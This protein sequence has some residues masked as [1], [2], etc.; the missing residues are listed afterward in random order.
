METHIRIHHFSDT[1][2][3]H[4]QIKPVENIDI[5]IFTGD[6]SNPRD[7]TQSEREI[8]EFIDWYKNYPAKYRVFIAGNHDCAIAA[9]RVT[10]ADF[11]SVGI[12]YLENSY[13]TLLG[14][15]IFGTPFTPNFGVGWA[16]NKDRA[17]M[18]KIWDMVDEG[19]DIIASHGPCRSILDLTENRNGNLEQCGDTDMLHQM[20]RIKPRLVLSGHI[21]NYNYCYN[22]GTR[23]LADLPNTIF[24]NG[25]VVMDGKFEF[26]VIHNGNIFELQKEE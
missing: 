19:T 17:K 14:L 18:H 10:P 22:Q 7:L 2:G 16:F 26:G 11:T 23:V 21:H 5:V 25:S 8:R 12:I 24:S 9:R 6:C 1:H 13:T 3:M 4:Y 15:R 20:Y